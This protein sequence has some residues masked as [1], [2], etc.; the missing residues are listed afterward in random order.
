MSRRIKS[1]GPS[2]NFNSVH[3]RTIFA[4]SSE[5]RLDKTGQTFT[6]SGYGLSNIY[7]NPGN[8]LGGP[9]VLRNPSRRF[10]DPEI[11][12]TAIYLPRQIKQKNR[13][14]RWFYDHDEM[15]GAVL[16]LHAELPYSKAEI[17]VDDP[18]IKR[19]VEECME[20]T[21]FFSHLPLIDLEYLKMGEVF[22][23]TPWD[24]SKGMWS[25]IILH[26]PDFVEVRFSPFADSESSIELVPDDEL[27]SL[28]HST[29]PEEQQLKKKIP[30][31]IV[32]RVLTGKNILL[33]SREITHIARKSNPYD[34]RGTSI[35]ER[36]FRLLMF[37]DK[38][39]EAQITIADN[40]IYPLKIFKLGDPQKGWIPNESHQR[41]L[42][43][44]LQQAAFDPN[45]ALIYHYALQVEYVTVADKILKLDNEWE[46]INK[47]KM[48]ALGVSQQ[49][50]N[51]DTTYAS[52]NVGLQTQLARYKAKR[53]LFEV[54]WIN[55]KFFRGMAERNE[56]YQH[57]AKEI[58][59]HYRV[60]RSEE[61]RKKRLI[62]PKMIWHKKL[63][64]RDDQAYLNF[65]HNVYAQG[66]GPVSAITVLL[67]MGLDLDDELVKKKYQRA[68]EERIGEYIHPP[69]PAKM[70]GHLLDKLRFGK[71][72]KLDVDE[73]PSDI[74]E[75]ESRDF[76]GT[77]DS[78]KS[79]SLSPAE[80]E[81]KEA[82]ADIDTTREL[83]P[84]DDDM[85]FKN[86]QSP[87]IPAEVV[88]KLTSLYNKLSAIKKKYSNI[89]E[90]IE[91]ESS[92]IMKF[93]VD[94]YMQGK[95]TAY[96]STDYLPI[97]QKYYSTNKEIRDYSDLALSN[98]FEEWLIALASVDADNSLV[99][100][101]VRN[102]GN[103]CFIYG[104]LKGF[105]EQGIYSVKIGNVYN[106]DGIRY[107]V[108]E[109][110]DKGLNV[111]SI[112]SPE[113]EIVVLSA[114]IEGFEE[115]DLGNKV[116][117]HIEK[118]K[119]F[120]SNGI[121]IK[122]CPVEYSSHIDRYCQKMGIL[123]KKKY[124]TVFFV[125]DIIDL[126]E[127]EEIFR[128]K[129][130]K[131]GGGEDP[132]IMDSRVFQEKAQKKGRL[133]SF[134]IGRNLYLSNWIGMEDIPLT[135]N[136]IKHVELDNDYINKIAQRVFKQLSYDLSSEELETY[137]TFKYIEPI[138]SS[139]EEPMGWR[140]AEDISSRLPQ[141]DATEKLLAGKIWTISGK[142]ER[143]QKKDAFQI[144]KEHLRLWID[145]P[146][147]LSIDM[148]NSFDSF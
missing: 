145:Y 137:R 1:G 52:A 57:D 96:A 23:H 143:N 112:V 30:K 74:I 37:E 144:W 108:S 98:Q 55:D 81:T 68:M 84:V 142:C 135:E 12:T 69:A 35:I 109:L 41:A 113:D 9:N 42:A 85:W 50:L 119:D 106:R 120:Y 25:H 56:W 32:R 24:A 71:Q 62:L 51:G 78:I 129:L 54:R 73:I 105:Q 53:D 11:T 20:N 26:N 66:K 138:L 132:L 125:K 100:K 124:D 60:K 39:R 130:K 147:R 63:M 102:L 43:Q 139:S 2:K 92:D 133:A 33:D 16:D 15:V 116:D 126:P 122:S 77:V 70:A 146:Q 64:M 79:S 47:K 14:K 136:L 46:E 21:K 38:L 10:Y 114:C 36:L 61:E 45:F 97:Y 19:H 134:V 44:M 103:T 80:I 67:S 99:S 27:K 49:F 18:S 131:S 5:D 3:P 140:V 95:L 121:E 75:T 34:V 123:L 6:G 107:K 29:K 7:S 28:L 94:M 148:K 88:L 82:A 93:L 65:L 13:W 111:G 40:F 127:W 17:M 115:E 4:E 118:Y 104:Q 87:V 91:K 58:V 101:R 83:L 72:K 110:L 86:L 76:I 48:I 8:V 141:G 22:I 90:G 117:S 59:G 128:K 31:D 89:R